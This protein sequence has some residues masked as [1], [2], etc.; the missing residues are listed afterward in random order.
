MTT[1]LYKLVMILK[2]GRAVVI[3]TSSSREDLLVQFEIVL[4]RI[5]DKAKFIHLNSGDDDALIC[6][7]E[8]ATI[9]ISDSQNSY[10]MSQ[11]NDHK[12]RSNS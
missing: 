10:S 9:M 6:V 3:T 2:G 7:D 8:I 1:N 11:N 12:R 4:E 5:K